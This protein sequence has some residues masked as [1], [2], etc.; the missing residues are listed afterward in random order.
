MLFGPA[1][2]LSPCCWPF[3]TSWL[4]LEESL[5]L[6]AELPPTWAEPSDGRAWL[7]Q[8]WAESPG[9]GTWLEAWWAKQRRVKRR[10][11][12]LLDWRTTAQSEQTGWPWTRQATPTPTITMEMRRG[13]SWG[14]EAP[15]PA[16]SHQSLVKLYYRLCVFIFYSVIAPPCGQPLTRQATLTVMNYW[17]S[18]N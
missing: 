10:T 12:R 1:P 13:W 16:D 14:C 9:I 7:K 17:S 5:S 6:Q 4:D 2:S 3:T 8:W 18:L 15:P 11:Q